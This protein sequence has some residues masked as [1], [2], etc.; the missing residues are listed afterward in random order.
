MQ[1]GHFAHSRGQQERVLQILRAEYAAFG[2]ECVGDAVIP[3]ERARVRTGG[4]RACR[5]ASGFHQDDR[6]CDPAH[7]LLKAPGLRDRLHIHADELRIR[8]ALEHGQ[9]IARIDACHIAER[10]HDREP[11]IQ[12][13]CKIDD[14]CAERAGLR[15]ECDVTCRRRL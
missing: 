1:P 7:D 5:G 6:F 14:A 3:R 13:A 11:D 2:D 10:S 15:Q 8:V 4:G 12:F 9:Q